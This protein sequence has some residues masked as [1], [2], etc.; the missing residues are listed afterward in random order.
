[1]KVIVRDMIEK[2][3]TTKKFIFPINFV[4]IFFLDE[5][6]TNFVM[7]KI[8]RKLLLIFLQNIL[9]KTLFTKKKL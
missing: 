2:T 8:C 7:K 5:I 6:L 3:L 9:Y 4:L 1:M